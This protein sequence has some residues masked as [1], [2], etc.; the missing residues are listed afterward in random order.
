MR[1][2]TLLE[3]YFLKILTTNKILKN[4][5]YA[6]II[7]K[8][9]SKKLLK[10]IF[11]PNFRAVIS[12]RSQRNK[13]DDLEGVYSFWRQEYP[14]GNVFGAHESSPR[15]ETIINM[16]SPY[17]SLENNLLEVGC[18]IGRN[19]NQ[20]FNSG[21]KRL[22]G[23]EI[24][25]HAVERLRQSYPHLDSITVDIGP[26]EKVLTKYDSDSFDVVFTM[27]VIEHIHP[28]S[29]DLFS[30]IARVAK[31][32]VMAIEPSNGHSSH[33]QHPW[34]VVKEFENVGLKLIDRKKWTELWA[35]PLTS[36]NHWHKDCDAYDAMLFEKNN[37]KC[38]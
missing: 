38:V 35:V 7:D 37:I 14:I 27:A 1:G 21:Y 11:S 15:S 12:F 20:L 4:Q 28:S 31:K 25:E 16:L 3:D 30:E 36:E 9:L 19:L 17:I 10:N 13:I 29:I 33:R 24:S 26:A 32:Y 8:I 34:N 23:I 18:N 22:G 5:K 6:R 2:K